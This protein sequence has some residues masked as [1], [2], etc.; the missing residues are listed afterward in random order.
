M[1]KMGR[2]LIGIATI[3]VLLH[4]ITPHKHHKSS[5]LYNH[6]I[7][8]VGNEN[9]LINWLQFIFHPDLGEEH[10]ENYQNEH[11]LELAIPDFAFVAVAMILIPV[12]EIKPEHNTPYFFSAKDS[13]YL[14]SKQLRGPPTLV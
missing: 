2:F 1:H 5:Q 3:I 9:N 6:T 10:L 8:E 12:V 13:E 14:S 11:P 4:S 7:S